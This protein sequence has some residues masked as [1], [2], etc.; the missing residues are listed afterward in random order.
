[1]DA[2][3]VSEQII[4]TVDRLLGG[5]GVA[6]IGYRLANLAGHA[7]ARARTVKRL[8]EDL[9]AFEALLTE[10]DPDRMVGYLPALLA[11]DL[12]QIRTKD[13]VLAVCL[14]DTFE[15]VQ[16]LPAE[17]RG[18]E[19][20]VAR[21]VYLMPNVF[22]IAASRR[23]LLWHDPVRSIGLTYGGELR[24]PG[25]AGLHGPNDQFPLDGFDE[26]AAQTYL[27][28]RLTQDGQ[29]VIPA[30]VRQRIIDG[31]GGSPHYLELSAGL[32][33]Q[34][35]ARDED[36]QPE[37]FGRPFPE[38]V[39]RV[40]RD[41]SAED[42]E[43]LR[44]AALL[45]AF[46]EEILS[47][48]L[49]QARSR[50]I[51]EFLRRRFVR[52]DASV[53]P[54]YRLHENLRHGVTSCDDHTPDGWTVAERRRNVLRVTTYLE[55]IVLSIWNENQSFTLP[56]AERSRRTIVAFL[57][58]LYAAAEHGVLPAQLGHM[59]YTLHELGHWQVLASLPD[60]SDGASAE[61]AQ[62]VA[63]ARLGARA[64]LDVRP[65][66]EQMKR[67]AGDLASGTY[68]AYACFELGNLAFCTGELDDADR[69]FT[70]I[71]NEASA[72]GAGA[73]FGLAGIAIRQSRFGDHL[74]Y[75]RKLSGA[76]LEQTRVA[77][78]L[79]HLQMHNG[80]FEQA[81]ELFTTT[82][83]Y[84]RQAGAPLWVARATRHLALACMWFDPDRAFEVIPEARELNSSLG[85]GIGIAQCD[86][87][88]ALS[89]AFCGEW[90]DAE[91]RLA[92]ARSGFEAVGATFEMLPV[93]PVEAL[94][95]LGQGHIKEA[96]S[97]ARRLATATKTRRPLG[98]PVWSAITALWVD[99]PDWYHFD[100]IDW[101]EPSTARER[102]MA[103][104]TRLRVIDH[105]EK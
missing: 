83:E 54:S 68:A 76:R 77:D 7:V 90:A 2:L 25:L 34:I 58:A 33:E 51:E 63:V 19:D 1:M 29:P 70:A 24:W 84:A 10:R 15:N 12:E 69:Y 85:D 104:L 59:A 71:A 31:A 65:R 88:A 101:I 72:L 66:Y 21:L 98:P 74:A 47:A 94:L 93:D 61:L 95:H 44:A 64:D 35:A 97:V 99:Q 23:P 5:F 45:E 6:G 57:L 89:H 82:L 100:T 11:Y 16:V 96:R 14:L 40:M 22:F 50:Q 3:R 9:P 79:G 37:M 86:M 43:L 87:A 8:R 91:R 36:P 27:Q 49:P 103:P 26:T 52:H 78:T 55:G 75:T 17:R 102:W 67:A 92:E 60:H 42:R 39:L 62:L 48:V 30:Q 46:D 80:R 38:L 13:P 105:D 20:L 28:E 56:E 73:L 53:W 41:L 18:L 4:S 32:F 81:A